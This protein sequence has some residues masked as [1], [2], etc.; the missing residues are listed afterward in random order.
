MNRID[1]PLERHIH[2]GICDEVNNALIAIK[3]HHDEQI[4]R[5]STDQQNKIIEARKRHPEPT[6]EQ[7]IDLL[8]RIRDEMNQCTQPFKRY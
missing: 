2:D 7:M 6:W 5:E 1:R 4:A 3:L 8:T